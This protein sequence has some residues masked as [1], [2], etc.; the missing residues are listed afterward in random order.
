MNHDWY[1]DAKTFREKQRQ[2]DD[3]KCGE[4]HP[5]KSHAQWGREL[6][7]L[8][9]THRGRWQNTRYRS[10]AGDHGLGWRRSFAP[11]CEV[12]HKGSSHEKWVKQNTWTEPGTGR[13]FYYRAAPQTGN[14]RAALPELPSK[15]V[16]VGRAIRGQS[17]QKREAVRGDG[18]AKGAMRIVDATWTL[19]AKAYVALVLVAIVLVLIMFGRNADPNNG[20]ESWDRGCND[21]GK[22]E[23]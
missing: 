11:D 5:R 15:V 7:G 8:W 20:C 2:H 18:N 6:T 16:T 14:R 22:R 10:N 9:A 23:R 13:S 4:A 12:V 1:A 19:L 21:Y 17:S 3:L